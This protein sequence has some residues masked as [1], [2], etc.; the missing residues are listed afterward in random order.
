MREIKF[1]AWD[2]EE[3]R[4]LTQEEMVGIG[5]YYYNYGIG[6][7]DGR[8]I[9]LQFI[10]LLDKNGKEIY[11]GDIIQIGDNNHTKVVKWV[12]MEGYAGDYIWCW[13]YDEDFRDCFIIGNIHEN[14]ELLTPSQREKEEE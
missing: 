11:E 1:R 4:F 13:G 6:D 14:P 5:G 9:L 12:L 2:T 3:K 8:F 10:G 7:C